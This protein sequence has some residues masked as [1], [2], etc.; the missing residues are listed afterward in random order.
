M[1]KKNWELNEHQCNKL[2]MQRSS[3]ILMHPSHPFILISALLISASPSLI[4]GSHLIT[5][6]KLV[7]LLSH[8]LVRFFGLVKNR[9][10]KGPTKNTQF[11]NIQF[12]YYFACKSLDNYYIFLWLEAG[13][14]A[15]L[16]K[17]CVRN[18]SASRD[19]PETYQF[20]N[21]KNFSYF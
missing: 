16:M 21:G 5:E 9:H 15:G 4:M 7:C 10:Y 6:W 18:I 14:L 11:S 13:R 1:E 12:A 17:I 20:S 3:T 19:F 8:Y 2:I